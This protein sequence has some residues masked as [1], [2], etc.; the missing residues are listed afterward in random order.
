MGVPVQGVGG[1]KGILAWGTC[2]NGLLTQLVM[3]ENLPVLSPHAS[4]SAAMK[5]KTLLR[6]SEHPS[7]SGLNCT[8]HQRTGCLLSFGLCA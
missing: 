3:G 4:P 6:P 7:T 5:E 2:L 8:L 1:S